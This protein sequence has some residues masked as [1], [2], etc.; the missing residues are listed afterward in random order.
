MSS[1]FFLYSETF[2]RNVPVIGAT[3]R[4]VIIFVT[5][6]SIPLATAHS[7]ELSASQTSSWILALYGVSSIFSLMLTFRYRQPIMLTGNIFV[8]LFI[9]QLGGQI[10]YPELIGAS[11]LAGVVVLLVTS[12]GLT[13]RL[14]TWIPMPIVF[15]LLVGAVVPF[16]ANIFTQTENAPWSVGGA[17][18][19]YLVSRRLLGNRFPAIL[20]ALIAGLAI[21]GLTG[22]F[23]QAT[24]HLLHVP[25]ITHPVF[26]L[27]AIIAATP[28]FVILITLQANL[29]SIIF[30]KSQDYQP[31]E[32]AINTISGVGTMLGSLLGPTGVSLS[33]PVTSIVAGAGAGERSIRHRSIYWAA[34][35]AL[36]VGLLAGIAAG[37]PEIIPL[38]LLLALA[39][40]SVVDVLVSALPRI[41]E[42][43]LV[44]GPLFTFAIALSEISLFGFGPFFWA[45]V[46]GTGISYFLE[47]DALRMLHTKTDG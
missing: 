19:A 3:V 34:G 5:V 20:P 9:S 17:F 18:V 35:L 36:L 11:V 21:T 12:L 8:I 33:L 42:G 37:L 26:S 24:S 2:R 40:L 43:P 44:L 45:L 6:L 22:Q 41:V 27:S 38:P 23:G 29:P 4:I 16:V 10:G 32:T 47:R 46:I 25:E 30:L 28:V 7:M 14:S 13:G 1:R 15:G 31:P 39:G